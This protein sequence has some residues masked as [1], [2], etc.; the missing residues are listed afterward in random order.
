MLCLLFG[1]FWGWADDPE[2]ALKRPTTNGPQPNPGRFFLLSP[3]G[4]SG[5]GEKGE[6]GGTIHSPHRIFSNQTWTKHPCFIRNAL[7]GAHFS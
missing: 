5:R 2:H 3:H 7:Q 1:G 4:P 6:R